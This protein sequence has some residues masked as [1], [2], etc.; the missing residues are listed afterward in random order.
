M[1]ITFI[2]HAQSHNNVMAYR[3]QGGEKVD[4]GRYPNRQTDPAITALGEKQLACLA[5]F[6][7]NWRD[8]RLDEEGGRLI[9]AAMTFTA[10]YCSPMR[11]ALQSAAPIAAALGLR[12]Q[13]DARIHEVGGIH[14]TPPFPPQP[15]ALA[16]KAPRAGHCLPGLKRAEIASEFPDFSLPAAISAEGWWR[17]PRETEAE[18]AARVQEFAADM[19]LLA[20]AEANQRLA[21]VTHGGFLNWLLCALFADGPV[22]DAPRGIRYSHYNTALTRLDITRK[23]RVVLRFQNR[24]PHLPPKWLSY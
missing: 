4:G 1:E 19:R 22:V 7:P 23:G 16:D 18:A 14:E 12:P 3:A 10:L 13:V 5:A 20:R 24:T 9:P 11:R 15:P 2:R 21:F 8:L 6:L 17:R